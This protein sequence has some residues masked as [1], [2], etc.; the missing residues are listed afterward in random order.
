MSESGLKLSVYF[1]ESDRVGGALLSDDLMDRIAGAGVRASALLRGVE[2]FGITHRLRTDRILTLSED[3]PLVVVAV[4]RAGPIRTLADEV[5]TAMPRGLLT[6]ERVTLPGPD[7]IGDLPG[8]EGDDVKLTLFCGRGEVQGGRP[9]VTAAV[10][11]MREAGLGGAIALAGL[12]GTLLGERRRARFMA[13]NTGVPAMIVSVGRRARVAD[14]LP[15]LR[16]SAGPHVLVLERV[17]VVRRDGRVLAE[18]PAPPGHDDE[19]LALWQRVTVSCG[20]GARWEGRPLHDRL[21]RRL[22]E[23]DAAGATS[24]RG[25]VGYSGAAG[26]HADRV[27]AVR[28][29]TPI[30]VTLVDS[31]AA[32][33]RLW[34]IVARATATTGLVT[35]EIVPA[36]HAIAPGGVGVGG[37]RMA[38]PG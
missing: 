34:P 18:L 1:G 31:V 23:A 17:R 30:V 3:M 10:D 21:V 33:T 9:V 26:A 27:L 38:A 4:D 5:A 11:L 29:R 13:R 16:R 20:E 2:G 28:R 8:D 32:V 25:V 15:R 35:C 37:L 14:V 19:G 12:D 7:P 22:R 6:L 24:L 36:Y